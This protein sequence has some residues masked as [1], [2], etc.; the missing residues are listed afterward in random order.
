MDAPAFAPV[1]VATPIVA[2][3]A[4]LG[5]SRVLPRRVVDAA[6]TAAD[7]PPGFQP[8]ERLVR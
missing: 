7:P 2:A 8:R 6:A 1:A 5:L 3:C 4:L